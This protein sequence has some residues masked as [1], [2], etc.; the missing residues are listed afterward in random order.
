MPLR[1]MRWI[2]A[3]L[4][5]A[6]SLTAKPHLEVSKARADQARYN[7]LLA[8]GIAAFARGAY[9]TAAGRFERAQQVLPE[10][11]LAYLEAG[12]ACF[13]GGE[14]D[15]AGEHLR[16]GVRRRPSW[17]RTPDG[18]ARLTR[19]PRLLEQRTFELDA[20]LAR[21][22]SLDR[23]FVMG[24]VRFFRG[25]RV[26]ARQ[27]FEQALALD[28]EDLPTRLFLSAL[29]RLERAEAILVGDPASAPPAGWL[30]P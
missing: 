30:D 8:E 29:A 28:G 14:F 12:Q 1:P 6:A 5:L 20:E 11:P 22:A 27:T 4:L 13:A 19:T 24:V 26:A 10:H 23:L 21:V 2:G 16:A 7:Q 18:L 15:R 17:P 9:Q 3:G 25:D